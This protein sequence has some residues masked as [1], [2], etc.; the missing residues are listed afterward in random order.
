MMKMK[1][2]RLLGLF[3]LASLSGC[4]LSRGAPAP[5]QYV[6]GGDAPPQEATAR[7]APTGARVGIRRLEIASYLLVP[8]ILTRRAGQEITSS[9]FHRWGEPLDAGIGRALAG[10]L[11]AAAPVAVVDVAP[12][13]VRSTHDY[14]VQVNVLRFEAAAAADA[15][16]GEVVIDATWEI[17]RA[18]DE[19]VLQRGA[20]RFSAP[21][22]DVADY[23]NLV[24]GF[25]EG[26]QAL[27]RE[28]SA[29]LERAASA[30]P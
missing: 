20:T 9:P 18:S 29:G 27:A 21:R 15:T 6:L 28:L 8:T 22:A 11:R 17:L 5:Q 25:N 23:A 2:V 30:S 10:Y 4:G 24:A 1:S 26:L 12:W 7:P 14:L 3:A 16:A 13:P 19:T